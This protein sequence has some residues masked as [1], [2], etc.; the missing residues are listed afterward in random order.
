MGHKNNI[1][2]PVC[3]DGYVVKGQEECDDGNT[4]EFDGCFMCYYQCEEMCTLCELGVCYEC[5]VLGWIIESNRCIP[6]CGDGIV[7]GYEQ[8]DD[9]NEDFNDGCY[10]CLLACD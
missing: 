6:Y 1:C 5:D 7:T 8:C 4:I 2:F 9:M 10:K 3:G